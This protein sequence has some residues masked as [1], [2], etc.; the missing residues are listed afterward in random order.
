MCTYFQH[1]TNIILQCNSWYLHLVNKITYLHENGNGL[2]HQLV[3]AHSGTLLQ[4]PP[5]NCYLNFELSFVPTDW[6]CSGVLHDA[7]LIAKSSLTSVSCTANMACLIP[8]LC[9][10]SAPS[11][12]GTFFFE[13][14]RCLPPLD[15]TVLLVIYFRF[16]FWAVKVFVH[17]RFYNMMLLCAEVSA[18]ALFWKLLIFDLVGYN[19]FARIMTS[20][21][22]AFCLFCW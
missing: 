13:Q 2:F 4:F 6:G 11:S 14:E 18:L 20:F 3:H 12:V 17:W 7:L 22:S 8:H 5:R 15:C 16:L 9:S 1:C 10:P 21:H 19:S